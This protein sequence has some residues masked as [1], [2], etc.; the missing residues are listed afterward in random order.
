MNRNSILYAYSED[1]NTQK[2]LY[3]QRIYAKNC[4]VFG[5]IVFF[6]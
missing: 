4:E 1:K 5:V 3:R 6:S 2:F